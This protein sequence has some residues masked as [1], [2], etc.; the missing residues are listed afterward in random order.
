VFDA[1][2]YTE[3]IRRHVCRKF[4]CKNIGYQHNAHLEHSK[5]L[6]NVTM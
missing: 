5:T 2:R 1:A 6:D 4:H 3:D